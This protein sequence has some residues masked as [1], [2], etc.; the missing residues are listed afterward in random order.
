MVRQTFKISLAA[1]AFCSLSVIFS[2]G[3]YTAAI[4]LIWICINHINRS[5]V[6]GPKS[7]KRLVDKIPSSSRRLFEE[8][9]SFDTIRSYFGASSQKNFT[10]LSP[11]SQDEE[12]ANISVIHD[13]VQ[14]LQTSP[15]D[16]AGG[17]RN[18][19]FNQSKE[20]FKGEETLLEESIPV[21]NQRITFSFSKCTS[22][23]AAPYRI[24]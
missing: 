1:I 24:Y 12:A 4:R 11:I 6:T 7:F 19:S 22:V 18:D 9:A 13:I 2:I 14:V 5:N 16:T 15:E 10:V 8:Q 21:A 17:E 20:E 23:A 3:W